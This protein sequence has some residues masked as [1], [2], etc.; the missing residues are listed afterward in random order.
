MKIRA[1]IHEIEIQKRYEESDITTKT[2][3][4]QPWDI[5]TNNYVDAI[6]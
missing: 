2:I 5:T 3:E 1:E 6:E 4:K